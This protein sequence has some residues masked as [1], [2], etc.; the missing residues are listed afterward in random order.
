MCSKSKGFV[1]ANYTR[2]MKTPDESPEQLHIICVGGCVNNNLCVQ[3]SPCAG[4][5]YYSRRSNI[6]LYGVWNSMGPEVDHQIVQD[7]QEEDPTGL[8]N[9]LVQ[10]IGNTKF[11]PRI[12]SL[13]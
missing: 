9:F 1:V 11:M 7:G 2:I 3:S 13:K 12:C 5:L 8:I 6:D 4:L 10:R